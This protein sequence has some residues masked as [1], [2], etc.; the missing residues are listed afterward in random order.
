MFRG[1]Q[2]H[3]GNPSSPSQQQ[4][5]PQVFDYIAGDASFLQVGMEIVGMEIWLLNIENIFE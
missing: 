3:Y 2:N 5:E 4:F 1:K